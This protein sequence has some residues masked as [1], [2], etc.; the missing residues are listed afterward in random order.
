MK[1]LNLTSQFYMSS[2]FNFRHFSTTTHYF[3]S[4]ED[5]GKRKATEEDIAR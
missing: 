3:T 4:G 5:K 1:K 2:T